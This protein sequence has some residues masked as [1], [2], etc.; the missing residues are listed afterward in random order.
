VCIEIDVFFFEKNNNNNNG[1]STYRG[2]RRTVH[3][4]GYAYTRKRVYIVY[5]IYISINM[6]EIHDARAT[7]IT[8]PV[9]RVMIDDGRL[10]VRRFI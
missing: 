8:P 7:S 5:N 9:R 1:V 4:L 3:F 10:H 6:P 2:Q